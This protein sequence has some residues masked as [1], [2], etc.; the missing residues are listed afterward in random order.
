MVEKATSN[1]W[2]VRLEILDLKFDAMIRLCLDS[3]LTMYLL[4]SI[5]TGFTD[6]DLHGI[7]P[8][9]WRNMLTQFGVKS[10]IDV[11]CGRG[12]STLWFVLQGVDTLCVEGS[13][14]AVEN[15][16]LPDPSTQ[17]VE[18]DFSR[19]NVDDEKKS[20]VNNLTVN[21]RNLTSSSHTELPNL[22]SSSIRP[23]LASENL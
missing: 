8:T 11:G 20:R 18:H 4:L 2:E 5:V 16:L 7:S 10:L 17:M 15:S 6:I 21:M 14:D 9:V 3:C 13:H 22:L 12:I 19:G 23:L 1:T